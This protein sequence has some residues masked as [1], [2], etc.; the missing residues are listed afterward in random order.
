MKLWT[1]GFGFLLASCTLGTSME[2]VNYD[3]LFHDSN[4]KVWVVNKLMVDNAVISPNALYDKHLI[5][6]YRNRNCDYIPFRD[7]TREAPRKGDFFVDSDKRTLDIKFYDNREEWK[8]DFVYL[9]EDSILLSPR[10]D[11]DIQMSMQLKPFQEL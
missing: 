3:H 7:L 11:S 10:K 5:I 6:F 2:S 9:T 4:S 1:I 8:L